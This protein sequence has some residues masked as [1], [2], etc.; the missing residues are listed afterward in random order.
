MAKLKVSELF[1]HPR[2]VSEIAGLPELGLAPGSTFDLRSD[3]EGNSWDFLK[4]GGRDRAR[5]QIQNHKPFLII[6]SPPCTCYSPLMTLNKHR[7]DPRVYKRKLAE[8]KI[9]FNFTLKIYEAQLKD[10]RHYL[11]DLPTGARCKNL[12]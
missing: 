7:M 9:L 6:G 3:P 8:A 1:S 12:E 4:A 2:V 5:L 10:G 11:H